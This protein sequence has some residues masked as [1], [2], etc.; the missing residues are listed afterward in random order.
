MELT[1]NVVLTKGKD[2]M[3]GSHLTV[4][5]DSDKA[6]L[7]NDAKAP[8]APGTRVQAVILPNTEQ[9]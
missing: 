7:T 8:G 1:G 6:V 4:S 3:R 9:H 5:L 2:V